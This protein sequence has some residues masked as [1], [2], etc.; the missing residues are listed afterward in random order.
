MK[1]ETTYTVETP[2]PLLEFLLEHIQGQSR[3]S[4]KHLL[5]RGQVLVDGIPQKQ[6]DLTLTP[7]QQVALT[8]PSKGPALPFPVLYEDE[9]LI[10]IHKP[11]GLLSVGTEAE[12][13]RTA[14]R[15][16]SDHLRSRNSRSRLLVVHRLDRDTS[17]V[18]LF[19]KDPALKEALQEDWNGLVKKRGYLAI[20][21]GTDLP[22]KGECRSKLTENKVHRVHST[23]G[24]GKEAVTLYRVLARRGDYALLEVDIQTGRKNQIR[25]HLSELG[26]PVAGDEKY[27]AQSDPL[28]RLALHAK[29]LSLTD[30]RSG[31][32][33][34]FTAPAPREFGRLFPRL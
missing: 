23:K 20:V 21:E 10:A 4:V 34:T 28:G 18:L 7:G 29:I 1:K 26:Y 17:G 32:V 9:G 30:P 15:I 19:A 6:F 11:A 33:L 8:A 14:Y 13:K 31:K 3:N 12:K 5:S 25:S 22:D 16:L 27:G 24:E 2:V